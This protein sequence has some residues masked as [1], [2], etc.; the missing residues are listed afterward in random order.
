MSRLYLPTEG[1]ELAPQVLFCTFMN[2]QTVFIAGTN[3]AEQAAAPQ[4]TCMREKSG[5]KEYSL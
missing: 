5:D 1:Y 4:V 3:T 2:L